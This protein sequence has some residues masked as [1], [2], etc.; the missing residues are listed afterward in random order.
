[1]RNAIDADRLSDDGWIAIESPHPKLVAQHDHARS[2]GNIV[3]SLE[4]AATH[5]RDPER[6]KEP[7]CDSRTLEHLGAVR[8]GNGYVRRVVALEP[9][10]D[11]VFTTPIR[12]VRIRS[13]RA[14]RDVVWLR[15]V[16]VNEAIRPVVRQ[17]P[18]EDGVHEAEH[19]RRRAYA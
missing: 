11:V 10:E 4:C 9:G 13:C 5:R 3:V 1:M 12:E 14:T 19:R 17:R 18:K 16:D 8:V 2:T 7:G 6:C 15:L